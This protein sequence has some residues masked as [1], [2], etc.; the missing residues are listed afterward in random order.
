[1]KTTIVCCRYMGM[2]EKKMETTVV[3]WGLRF[4]VLG[5]V[6]RANTAQAPE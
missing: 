6:L 3:Y 5:V 4:W 2:M 1:M